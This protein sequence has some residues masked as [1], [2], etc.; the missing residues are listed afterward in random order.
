[1]RALTVC[2]A[3]IAAS[4]FM[5]AADAKE[6]RQPRTAVTSRIPQTRSLMP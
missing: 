3:L 6:F 2:A 1:M 5:Q 4:A